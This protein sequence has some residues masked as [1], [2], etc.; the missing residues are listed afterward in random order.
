M[1]F[2]V[3]GLGSMGKRR[4]RLLK[5]Y[6]NSEK[7]SDDNWKIFGADS[8]ESRRKETET[9]FGIKTYSGLLD[10]VKDNKID[11]ALISSPP[12]SHALIIKECLNQNLHVF[13]ELNLTADGYDENIALSK[14]KRK[15]LFLSSTFMYRREIQYIKKKVHNRTLKAVYHYHIGQYLPEWHP[16][17]P[18]QEFFAGQKQ[19]NGCREIF[20][21][22]LPWLI[23]IFGRVSSVQT[24]HKKIS[25]L[26]IEYDDVYQVLLEHES[27][28]IGNL[29]VDV[30]SP[31]AGREFEIWGEGFY[32]EWKGT[33]DSL[34]VYNTDTGTTEQISLYTHAE[35]TKGYNQF[36]VENA[37]YEELTDFIAVIREQRK[38]RYTFEKDKNILSLIDRIER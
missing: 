36:V 34:K 16:W 38:P 15:V 6:I 35:H 2:L 27:G 12:L 21:I 28:I 1:V 19:T 11:C 10:A 32:L 20:A 29:A 5:Q 33:P 18:Y 4:I 30:V 37:Y 13:T 9:L 17:E 26:N 25:D 31:K 3:I 14:E 24:I 22:E 7:L 8:R 23:D